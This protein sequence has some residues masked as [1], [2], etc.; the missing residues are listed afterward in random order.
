MSL[1]RLFFQLLFLRAGPE[2]MP[3]G[4]Q[5]LLIAVGFYVVVGV[6][7]DF[8]VT[9]ESGIG[10]N[11][12]G[13]GL[14]L[15]AADALVLVGYSAGLAVLRGHRARIPQ[16][17]TA[18]FGA[19][20]MLG[21]VAWPLVVMQPTGLEGENIDGQVGL[22]SVLMI[23]LF[24]WNLVVLGQIYRRTLD[25]GAAIGVLSALGYFI[26]S[27]LVYMTLAVQLLPGE[28]GLPT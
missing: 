1:I 20:A 23:A 18:L 21:L 11:G 9:G 27:S 26:L 13:A 4:Q 5:P 19:T 3:A 24:A 16:M 28:T 7:L 2:D 6:L 8:A 17:L 22:W 14:M 10:G 15:L 25:F 12:L